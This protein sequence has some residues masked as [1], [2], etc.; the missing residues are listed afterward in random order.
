MALCVLISRKLIGLYRFARVCRGR[1]AK[2]FAKACLS[3][4]ADRSLPFASLR[5]LR[6]L[7]GS[8]IAGQLH[9]ESSLITSRLHLRLGHW[10]L[11]QPASSRSF[12]FGQDKVGHWTGSA[13]WKWLQ[14]S[15][16]SSC[17]PNRS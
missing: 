11:E 6:F 10:Y 2:S 9:E 16:V 8:S 15:R 14:G 7:L 12:P 4:F 5:L 3:T 1:A 13:V 17:A